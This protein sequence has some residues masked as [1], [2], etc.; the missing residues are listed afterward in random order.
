[1]F[2]F[3]LVA[4]AGV[5]TI[6]GGSLLWP[7]LTRQSRPAP[8]Q[9]V[10]DIVI[11]T[12]LGKQAASVLGVTDEAAVTPI[13]VSS[14]AGSVTSSVISAVQER[15][16]EVVVRQAVNQLVKQFD[17]LNPQQKQEIKEAICKP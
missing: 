11:K 2:K 1:M 13:N 9:Q 14:L 15:T 17:Q 10:H 16:Q 8:L 6:G 4:L 7:K 12:D 5:L 3:V